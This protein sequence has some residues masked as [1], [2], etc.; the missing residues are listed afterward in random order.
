V[1]ST[2]VQFS[3]NHC[4]CCEPGL[5]SVSRMRVRRGVWMMG[6]IVV[7]KN[8]NRGFQEWCILMS[9]CEMVVVCKY[10]DVGHDTLLY[11][12]KVHL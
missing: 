9:L 7:V 2:S 4:R 3:W 5:V 1:A 8:V 11:C 10:L 6:C 12:S